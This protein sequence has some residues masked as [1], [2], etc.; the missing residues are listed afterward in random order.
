MPKRVRQRLPSCDE[1]SAMSNVLFRAKHLL[2]I[3]LVFRS[4]G[5]EI[6]EL[7]KVIQRSKAPSTTVHRDLQK[8]VRVGALERVRQGRDV[9]YRRV[10]TGAFWVLF[11]E[12]V[13]KPSTA[14]RQ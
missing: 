6:L 7:E 10:K 9:G 12:L 1:L 8:L 14:H 3:A 5:D 4:T 2:P 13:T 11:E